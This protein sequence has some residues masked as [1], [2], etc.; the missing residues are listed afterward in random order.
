[1]LTLVQDNYKQRRKQRNKKRCNQRENVAMQP[2]FKGNALIRGFFQ[3]IETPSKDN[4]AFVLSSKQHL[5]S[6]FRSTVPGSREQVKFHLK[7]R[8][9]VTEKRSL[10]PPTP[11]RPHRVPKARSL[12]ARLR[13][14]AVTTSAPAITIQ[15][16]IRRHLAKRLRRR[17][18]T[19]RQIEWEWK[20]M[21]GEMARFCAERARLRYSRE[22]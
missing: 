16:A 12:V 22:R 20:T 19:E 7:I 1:M 8:P 4:S 11:P 17:L 10:T 15:S 13:R 3:S 14:E 6:P 2:S 9:H 18:V 21:A 5:R